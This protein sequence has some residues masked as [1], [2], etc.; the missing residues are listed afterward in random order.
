MTTPEK[1]AK[2]AAYMRQWREA[3]GESLLEYR[4]EYHAKN[5]GR[6]LA[7]RKRRMTDAQV[8]AH[9]AARNAKRSG[10]VRERER[11]YMA[12]YRENPQ[13][14]LRQT[15]RAYT[16]RFPHARIAD[17][18]SEIMGCTAAEFRKHIEGKWSPG[19]TWDN[20][21]F[22]GWHMDHIVPLCKFDLTKPDQLRRARHFSNVQPLWA[23]DHQRKGT[24]A[25]PASAG[26]VVR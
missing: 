8:E 9:N 19:M 1:R 5:R 13:H 26:V 4:R 7:L 22:R 21:T 24:K 14:K 18:Y 17:R 23:H 3:K 2:R 15:I 11:Q 25:P 16:L 12:Q 20:Y 6:I 10:A